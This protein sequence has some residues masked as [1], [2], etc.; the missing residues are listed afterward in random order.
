[1][2]LLTWNCFYTVIGKGQ[3]LKF[4]WTKPNAICKLFVWEV[5]ER[6]YSKLF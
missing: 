4:D 2:L 3:K 1:M 6:I 5:Y